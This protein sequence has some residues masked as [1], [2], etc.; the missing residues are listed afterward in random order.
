MYKQVDFS[1]STSTT[2]AL[3]NELLQNVHSHVPTIT[4]INGG[5]YISYCAICGKILD[6]KTKEWKIGCGV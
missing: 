6:A 4:M 3:T 5:D 1:F 2:S